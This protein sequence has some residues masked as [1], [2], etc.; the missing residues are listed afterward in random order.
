MRR[1]TFAALAMALALLSACGGPNG[2]S[3]IP[4]PPP[5]APQISCP[6][7]IS[8][9]G[10]FG[11]AQPV[12]YPEPTTTGGTSPLSVACAPQSGASFPLGETAVTCTATDLQLRQASCSFTVTLQNK[13]LGL[14]RYLAFGDSITEGENGRPLAGFIPFID[15]ANAYPTVLQQ[16]FG[17]RIPSQLITVFNAG[18]G[19]ERISENESRLK[20]EIA[21]NRAEVLLLLEGINDLNGNVSPQAVV[22]GLRN[23]IGTAKERG[24]Q[25]VF[26]ST[27]LPVA[28]ENCGP[29][30][31]HC[32][33]LFTTNTAVQT[34][35]Q[36]IRG[37][38]PATGAHLVDP[39][40]LFFANRATYVDIDGLHLRPEGNRALANAFWERIVQVIP[41]KQLY[42]F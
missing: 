32:R 40:D 9:A 27:L 21:A 35:N 37:M 19:G 1:L 15:L 22:D 33:G 16:M 8:V 13:Q 17:E 30:P 10:A 38:V 28:P 42:G 34:T 29:A 23:T 18:R 12:T 11:P 3:Y 36:G 41:A 4:P 6:A 31:P 2:P 24:V 14:T 39:Y 20:A 7:S 26:V 5:P 25:Y